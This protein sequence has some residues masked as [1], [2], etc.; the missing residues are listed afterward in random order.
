VPARL[1]F[2]GALTAGT[3]GAIALLQPVIGRPYYFPGFAAVI[4]SAIVAGTR[5]GLTATAGFGLGYAFFYL[6]PRGSFAIA[7][8]HEIGGLAGFLITAAFVSWM[9]GTLRRAFIRLRQQAAALE[10]V[11]EQR[12]DLVRTLAHDLRSPLAVIGMNAHILR[13]G[14]ADGDVLRRA[15]GIEASVAAVTTM[16]EDLVEVTRL[17][18][19]HVALERR[20]VR[21]DALVTGVRDRVPGRAANDRVRIDVPADL[22]PVDVDPQR[23]ERVLVNLLSN[24]LKYAPGSSPVVLAAARDEAGVVLTVRDEGPGIAAQDLPRLFEKYYRAA[25]TRGQDGLGLGL[26]ISRLLVEAHGGR[27]WVTSGAGAGTTVHVALP[28]AAPEGSAIDGR[29][30]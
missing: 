10:R 19:G 25:S 1:A 5:Y 18:S 23:F 2:T 14:N 13:Q 21:L 30:S 15:T 16:L 12:E 6:A 22:P 17:E 24:A 11:Q 4:A 3:L 27:I 9:G 7:N 29:A 28:P 20:A 8:P 26:Y